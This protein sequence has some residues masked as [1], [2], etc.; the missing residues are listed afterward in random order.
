MVRE[1]I[2]AITYQ[3]LCKSGVPGVSIVSRVT[4]KVDVVGSNP[5]VKS[6]LHMDY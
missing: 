3:I 5:A 1:G 6:F 4:I 2:G